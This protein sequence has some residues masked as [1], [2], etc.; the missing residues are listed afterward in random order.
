MLYSKPVIPGM[1]HNFSCGM[2]W[3]A[4]LLLC[5][6]KNRPK[7][8]TGSLANPFSAF[9]LRSP[10]SSINFVGS[11]THPS[12]QC[13]IQNPLYLGCIGEPL[14]FYVFLRTDQTAGPVVCQ[15]P[16][17]KMLIFANLRSFPSKKYY[18]KPWVICSWQTNGAFG[19]DCLERLIIKSFKSCRS[20]LIKK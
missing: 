3:R 20:K 16:C 14:C 2:H 11:R 1:L 10:L 6:L 18:K 5:F 19:K 12:P 7:C 13:L 4:S 8:W 17:I 9:Y 15:R